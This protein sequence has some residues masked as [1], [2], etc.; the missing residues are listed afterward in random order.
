[1]LNFFEF[2]FECNLVKRTLK[3]E[4]HSS[5][6]K[7][8]YILQYAFEYRFAIPAAQLDQLTMVLR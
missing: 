6:M 4:K 5:L 2:L 3:L 7:Q 1:M 8:C